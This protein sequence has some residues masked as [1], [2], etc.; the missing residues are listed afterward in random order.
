M[1]G[2]IVLKKKNIPELESLI[3]ALKSLPGGEIELNVDAGFFDRDNPI[4]AQSAQPEKPKAVPEGPKT[5]AKS[6]PGKFEPV[7]EICT[8]IRAAMK[9]SGVGPEA[10]SRRVGKSHSYLRQALI[11]NMKSISTD[12]REKLTEIAGL[13]SRPVRSKKSNV[14]DIRPD[15]NSDEMRLHITKKISDL[16]LTTKSAADRMGI[17]EAALKKYLL[18]E[19]PLTAAHVLVINQKLATAA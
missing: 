3:T 19:K 6:S 2:H 7:E 17:S 11:G 13:K 9:E 16:G 12:A 1:L 15:I 5:K 10:L 18:G 14:V 4:F 8:L